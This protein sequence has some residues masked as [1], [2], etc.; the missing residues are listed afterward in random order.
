MKSQ[1]NIISL[2][3]FIIIFTLHSLSISSFADR[4]IYKRITNVR[5]Q[6][7]SISW[8]T[9][10]K[11][12]GIIKY[13]KDKSNYESWL[14]ACD[15]RGDLIKDDIH[16]V[17]I[18]H[19]KADTTYWYDIISGNTIDNNLGNHYEQKTGADLTPEPGSCQ[20]AGKIFI[21]SMNREPACDSIIYVTIKHSSDNNQSAPESFIMTQEKG[22]YWIGELFNART[23]DFNNKYIF[24]CGGSII[25]I[26]VQSG[27][28]GFAQ[29]TTTLVDGYIPDIIL[30]SDQD[31]L[32]E[33]IGL[34]KLVS[35]IQPEEEI[36]YTSF[37][38]NNDGIIDIADILFGIIKMSE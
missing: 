1:K 18:E 13:G 14:A 36:I 6:Q 15:D 26:K 5:G 37:D 20:T 16:H 9:E 8:I 4:P 21:D 38:N 22:G 17:T 25:D 2:Q 23:F 30:Q 12:V 3:F 19:L 29:L 24:N 11:E 31:E 27:N 32:I 10:N 33:L 7:F 34:I 35:G 28:N